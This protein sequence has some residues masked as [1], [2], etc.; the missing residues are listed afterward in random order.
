MKK[1]ILA[2]FLSFFLSF[3]LAFAEDSFVNTKRQDNQKLDSETIRPGIDRI[4]ITADHHDTDVTALSWEGERGHDGFLYQYKTVVEDLDDTQ[5]WGVVIYSPPEGAIPFMTFGVEVLVGAC[6]IDFYEGITGTAGSEITSLFFKNRNS[7]Q[8]RTALYYE[9]GAVTGLLNIDPNKFGL[10]KKLQN[11][12][13]AL[14]QWGL[15]HATSYLF[16]ITSN[17]ANNSFTVWMIVDE[18]DTAEEQ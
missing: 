5:K 2:L 1:I 12:I 11:G 18:Y 16:E 10:G 15:K 13:P 8:T 4:K 7:T 6:H 9:L 17:I 3:G 14:E